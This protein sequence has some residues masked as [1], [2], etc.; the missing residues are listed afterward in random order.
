[1]TTVESSEYLWRIEK[2]LETPF[3]IRGISAEP[4]LADLNLREYLHAVCCRSGRGKRD[5]GS[6]ACNGPGCMGTRLDWVIVG[7]ES[8]PGARE[9]DL[10]WA[11]S[12][13]KQ[14]AAANVACFVK[15]FGAKPCDTGKA[16]RSA[17]HI[18]NAR[19]YLSLKDGKGGDWDE[20]PA[21]LRVRQYPEVRR[22]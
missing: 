8:G 13:I 16:E 10:E 17:W 22:G 9:F 12:T 3:A 15:Q 19:R 18:E 20:W 5:D 14:C 1:M 21:D 6:D 2:L 4:L 11:R 7:G